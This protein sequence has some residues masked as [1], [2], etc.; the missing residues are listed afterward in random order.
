MRE[1]EKPGGKSTSMSDSPCF[2][3]G[4]NCLTHSNTEAADQFLMI[5]EHKTLIK[6]LVYELRY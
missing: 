6:Y 5:I 2:E 3:N 1:N 4:K